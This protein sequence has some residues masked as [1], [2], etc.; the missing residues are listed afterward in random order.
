MRQLLRKQ[1][2][3][4]IILDD[5][6]NVL[7]DRPPS[8]TSLG[9]TNGENETVPTTKD[10]PVLEGAMAGGGSGSGESVYLPMSLWMSSSSGRK[11]NVFIV[12]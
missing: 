9:P 10:E 12:K 3:P 8:Y 6:E 2:N 7:R 5:P 11:G 4:T 1:T